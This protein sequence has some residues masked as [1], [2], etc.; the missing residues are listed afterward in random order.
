LEHGV[1]T[2]LTNWAGNFTFQSTRLHRPTSL[3]ELQSI[4]A[5]APKIHALGSRHSFNEIADSAALIT[6]EG[7][8]QAIEIDRSART[9]T[10][11]AGMQY[12]ILA[13]ALER[14]GLALHNMASLPHITV[15]GAV[16]TAT[17]GSGDKNGNL[18]TAVA[19]IE[20]VTSDGDHLRVAR[21]DDDFAGMVVGLG[22]LGVVTRL[23]LD[24]QPSYLVRQE[25]FEHL[26]WE[27]LFDRFDEVMA[28]ADSVS[29][30]LDYGADVNQVWLKTRVDPDHPRPRLDDLLGAKAAVLQVHPARGFSPDNLTEQLGVPGPWAER[31]PHFRMEA[32]PATGSELQTEYMV[33]RRHAVPALQAVR[34]LAPAIRPLL[35]ASEIR[36]VAADDLWLSS[37]YGTDTVCIHFSWKR[38]GDAVN[39]LLP[40]LEA[41]LAPFAARPHWGKLFAATARELEPRFERL[42][43]FRW[44]AERL[45]R[46]G[47]FRNAFLERHVFG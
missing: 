32:I 9:V 28:S 35:L 45:D 39:G 47:A 33:P 11:N 16:A 8:D 4:V 10:V 20:L 2:S 27:V 1:A 46:R 14:A 15:G 40:A 31:L 30:F 3:A 43:D 34:G 12:G 38:D 37:A 29:V 25:V 42:P 36:T 23:T 22:A 13:L 18:A 21:N 17:H 19:R 26:A 6:L 5:R 24:V 41:A 7:L 44:L